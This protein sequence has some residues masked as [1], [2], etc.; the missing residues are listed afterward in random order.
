MGTAWASDHAPPRP[1]RVLHVNFND[2]AGGAGRAA[3]RLHVAQ[4]RIGIESSMLV[5]RKASAD[6]DV[7]PAPRWF[8]G[9]NLLADRI[10]G[11][12]LRHDRRAP[13]DRSLNLL[14]SRLHREINRSDADVVNLHW[15]HLQMMSVG[16]VARIAKP[17]VWTLHDA[18]S[19]CG[20]EHYFSDRRYVTG[21]RARGIDW[22]AWIWARKRRRWRGRTFHLVAPS[23]WMAECCR[24]SALF[25]AAPTFVVGNPVDPDEFAPKDRAEAR[26]RLGLPEDR[27]ILLFG[28]HT[29]SDRRKGA[30]LLAGALAALLAARPAERVELAVFGAQGAALRFP[31][32]THA[33]GYVADMATAYAA[34]DVLVAPSRIDNL[35]NTVA[36]AS[37]CG[38]PTVAF[39]VGG[40]P[41]LIE[42]RRTG[43]LAE[44]FEVM[45]LARGIAWVLDHDPDALGRAAREG[46]A[47]L[48]PHIVAG[49]YLDVYRRAI[50][51]GGSTE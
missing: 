37:A 47:L 46:A 10:E 13:G 24:Q 49:Q 9:R 22:D 8:R 14:P 2:G 7:R 34:A 50:A 40:L 41:E 21:Y 18:W 36:E 15:I 5:A 12:L 35:P 26:R 44:P 27:T 25:A 28:A 23:G 16:E 45:D 33:L 39:R 20:A 31:C 19:F 38:R 51:S 32:P 17:V 42:H 43:Y 48:A 1:L 11:W 6:P 4:R 29:A 3:Y 30:D